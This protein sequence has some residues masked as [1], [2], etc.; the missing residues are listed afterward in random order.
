MH[1]HIA[2]YTLAA[3]IYSYVTLCV[4]NACVPFKCISSIVYI[5]HNHIDSKWIAI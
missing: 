3:L 1:N 5:E 4:Y 2:S